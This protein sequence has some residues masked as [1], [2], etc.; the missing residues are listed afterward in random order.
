MITVGMSNER[1]VWVES[2]NTAG[3][4]GSGTLPVFATPAM[5]LLA[6]QTA[7]ECLIPGLQDGESSVGI[8][9]NMKHTAP[10]LIGAKVTCRAEVTEI[11]RARVVFDVVVSDDHG[12]IGTGTHERF[13]IK[14][15]RFMSK[16]EERTGS[17]G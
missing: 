13:V 15:D 1:S 10:S 14:A 17:S 5:I 12:V 9:V 4:M 16:A 2:K 11:D 8:L 6:E 3:S 7:S